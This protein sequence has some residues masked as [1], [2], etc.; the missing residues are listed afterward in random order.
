[1]CA[2]LGSI[3]GTVE[4]DIENIDNNDDMSEEEEVD[5]GLADGQDETENAENVENETD[6]TAEG[7]VAPK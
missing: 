2:I 3:M 5:L 4:E 6:G 1:M 7:T